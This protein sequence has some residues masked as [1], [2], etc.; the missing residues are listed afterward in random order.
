MGEDK[1]V[2]RQKMM[3]S[4][5]SNISL[6]ASKETG[7]VLKTRMDMLD[8]S[9]ADYVAFIDEDDELVPENVSDLI[10]YV[11][12]NKP[13]SVMSSSIV[14]NNMSE[15]VMPFNSFPEGTTYQNVLKKMKMPHQLII[16]KKRTALDAALR[17]ANIVKEH[18]DNFDAAWCWEMLLA[19]EMHFFP[20]ICYKWRVYNGQKQLHRQKNFMESGI[21]YHNLYIQK[22]REQYGITD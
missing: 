13:N 16:C 14:I 3:E 17:A 22:F 1:E 4:M 12:K 15:I 7:P 10:E 8:M 6:I 2:W 11:E 9:P 5:P 21:R 19:G 20:K 18:P